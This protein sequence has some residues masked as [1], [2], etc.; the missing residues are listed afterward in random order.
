MIQVGFDTKEVDKIEKAMSRYSK[1]FPQNKANAVLRKAVRP[2]LMAAF[3]EVPV[4]KGDERVSLKSA[5]GAIK[6]GYN[7]NYLRQGGAT[8]RDLR[9]KSVAPKGDELGRILVGVSKKASKV[10]WRTPFITHGTKERRTRGGRSTGKVAP[11]NFLQRAYDQ[12]ISMVRTDF[13]KAYREA[14][15]QWAKQNLPQSVL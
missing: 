8:R 12:T 15:V 6:K 7:P 13:Q 10:G 1:I 14:F 9:I 5:R 3:V 4:S 2:M 11:N